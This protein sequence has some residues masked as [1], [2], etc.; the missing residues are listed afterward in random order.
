MGCDIDRGAMKWFGGG[1]G[2]GKKMVKLLPPKSYPVWANDSRDVC[3]VLL[4]WSLFVIQIGTAH[5]K[6]NSDMIMIIFIYCD[7]DLNH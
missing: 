7:I 5:S 1:G 4:L 3:S 6:L 2:G